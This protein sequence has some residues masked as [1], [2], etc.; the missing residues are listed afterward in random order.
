MRVNVWKC[1]VL[2]GVLVLG[3]C[4]SRQNK[5]VTEF[6]SRST[7]PTDYTRKE[8]PILADLVDQGKLPALEQ[9]LPLEPKVVVPRDTLGNYCDTWRLCAVG[10]GNLGGFWARHNFIGLM[11]WSMDWHNWEPGVARK[12]E[13]RDQGRT[14]RFHL[15][16][17]HKWSDGQP[18]TARDVE[19]TVKFILN[20]HELTVDFPKWLRQDGVRAK[21]E[22][23]DDLTF[24]FT[25][26]RANGSFLL[27]LT[28]SSQDLL[29]PQH[30]LQQ[31][32]PP[33]ISEAEADSIATANGFSKWT[34]YF[35]MVVMRG[36]MNSD[37]PVLNPWRR[38]TPRDKAENRWIFERNPYYYVVDL[39]GR[40]L[41]Y[42][43]RLSIDNVSENE[44]LFLKVISGEI[45]YQSRSM[46][47]ER[48]QLLLR[49]RERGAYKVVTSAA[50]FPDGIFINQQKKKDPVGRKLYQKF[51]FRFA[52]S[53]GVNRDEIDKLLNCGA[54]PNM[55]AAVLPA[56][57]CDRPELLKWFDYDVDRANFI[58][59]TL[60]LD[61][62]ADGW[63]RRT[64][65]KQL[66]LSLNLLEFF[67]LDPVELLRE[68][69]Q[70]LGIKVNI[71]KRSYR[72]WWDFAKAGEF[73]LVYYSIAIYPDRR[74]IAMANHVFPHDQATYWAGEWGLWHS[75]NGKAGLEP[76]D[77]IKVLYKLNNQI[78]SELDPVQQQTY[79]DE[80][81]YRTLRLGHSIH[82]KSRMPELLIVKDNF[83]NY[84]EGHAINDWVLRGP[85]PDFPETFFMK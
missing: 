27:F 7:E 81:R 82:I 31:F 66:T 71:K 67:S 84:S 83:Y 37:M 52:L 35:T 29:K 61:R 2:I 41:P 36:Y 74:I 3:G 34:A 51:D 80:L 33:F 77:S 59:D 43:D 6:V 70:E 40:Q 75:S 42:F 85:S 62:G 21:F 54:A 20:N 50:I 48:V 69:W 12:C 44:N 78:C 58:L 28:A 49:N 23:I 68:Y 10:A 46:L 22:L 14:F 39:A 25:F 30:Y 56:G 60:G 1:C 55:K 73:D 63:R 5:T 32:I 65:G 53:L 4:Q 8:A 18:F 16:P 17:G 15:R 47:S 11:H 38:I 64:D 24:E 72:S 19:F 57:Y 26:P 45:D 13:V 76:P 79:I 9:R